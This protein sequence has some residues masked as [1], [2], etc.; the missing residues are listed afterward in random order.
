MRPFLFIV[1]SA[2]ITLGLACLHETGRNLDDPLAGDWICEVEMPTTDE[3]RSAWADFHAGMADYDAGRAVARQCN[4]D[5]SAQWLAAYPAE[6]AFYDSI[7]A[8]LEASEDDFAEFGS[9]QAFVDANPTVIPSPTVTLTADEVEALRPTSLDTSLTVQG[10]YEKFF[11]DSAADT[12]YLTS[13]TEG[14]VSVD[15]RD[16]YAFT[17]VGRGLSTSNDDFYVVDSIYAYAEERNQ[18]TG[19]ADLVVYDVSDPANPS[20]IGRLES[21][22]IG[23]RPRPNSS[24]VYDRRTVSELQTGIP[25][26]PPSFNVYRQILDG[27]LSFDTCRQHLPDIPRQPRL[28]ET[29]DTVC[30]ENGICRQPRRFNEPVVAAACVNDPVRASPNWG[31]D[32][33]AAENASGG[34]NASGGGVGGAGSLTQMRVRG[35]MLYVLETDDEIGYLNTFDISNRENPVAVHLLQLTLSPVALTLADNLLLVAGLE[36]MSIVSLA[37]PDFPR[38]VGQRIDPTCPGFVVNVQGD[39]IV[40]RGNTAYRTI[41][42]EPCLTN[43]PWAIEGLAFGSRIEAID[44][45]NPAQPRLS[46]FT[47]LGEPAGVA[48]LGDR[49][50]VTDREVGIHIFDVDQDGIDSAFGLISSSAKDLIID[51]FD[52][53][54]L[55]DETVG[56]HFIAP[57]FEAETRE[58]TPQNQVDNLDTAIPILN[59]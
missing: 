20:V 24:E 12:L 38:L 52:L 7:L 54:T 30:D 39:P 49:M 27:G 23:P 5:L 33:A 8:R 2:W 35:N 3:I 51:G 42:A 16:R 22:I 47:E 41:D 34:P 46:S 6:V 43:E 15:I 29:N 11:V 55:D 14:L 56:A 17:E 36:G 40:V 37:D 9:A 53:Y 10:R 19:F 58:Q 13:S 45:Q 50:F 44:I 48:I 57:L 59:F 21:A 32:A 26:L 28:N 31:W 25:D 4:S 18:T 1:V